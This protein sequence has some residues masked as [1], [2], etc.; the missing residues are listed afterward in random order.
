MKSLLLI[1]AALASWSILVAWLAWGLAYARG[2]RQARAEE[3]GEQS[4]AFD[5][6]V[7][8]GIA[9]ERVRHEVEP[10]YDAGEEWK[11]GGDR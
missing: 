3:R 6:G 2:A 5:R 7:A 8:V 10:G 1:T 11:R 4:A 9:A